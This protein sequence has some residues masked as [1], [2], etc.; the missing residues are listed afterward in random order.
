M[1]SRK[2]KDKLYESCKYNTDELCSS[3]SLDNA[4]SA[5][6]IAEQD[7]EDRQKEEDRVKAIEAAKYVICGRLYDSD[8]TTY[9][10]EQ[11]NYIKQFIEFYDK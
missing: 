3:L 6:R 8:C 4:I 11:C 7:A 2:A 1:K 9:G 10:C 5:I